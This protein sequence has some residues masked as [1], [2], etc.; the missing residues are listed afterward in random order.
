MEN[1]EK[2][3]FQQAIYDIVC[4]IPVGRATSYGAIAKAIGFSNFSRMVGKM[5][6]HCPSNTNIPAHR[7][8][9]SQGF[10]SAKGAFD[11]QQQLLEAEG[12]IVKNDKIQK[13]KII[14]WDPLKEL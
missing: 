13:W 8:V 7:V 1:S 3:A 11:T 10:L 14:F 5:M 6:S 12:V 4:L 9:N 2:Q